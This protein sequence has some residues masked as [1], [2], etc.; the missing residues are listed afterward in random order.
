MPG[1]IPRG[2]PTEPPR[3]S[4]VDAVKSLEETFGI[5]RIQEPLVGVQKGYL[6][7]A[8]GKAGRISLCAYERF[9]NGSPD[10]GGWNDFAREPVSLPAE[11]GESG[12]SLR[13]CERRLYS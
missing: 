4:L 1:T 9:F 13:E 7:I 11:S 8:F 6:R 2:T 5:G 3:R 12:I 10:H